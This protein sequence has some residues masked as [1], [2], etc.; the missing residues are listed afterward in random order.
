LEMCEDCRVKDMFASDS[1][2]REKAGKAQG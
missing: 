2:Q 1:G